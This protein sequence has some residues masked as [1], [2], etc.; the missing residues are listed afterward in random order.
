MSKVDELAGAM[1]T[2][3]KEKQI[4][5]SYSRRLNTGDFQGEEFFESRTLD[6]SE[7]YDV[8]SFDNSSTPEEKAIA[9]KKVIRNKLGNTVRSI[10]GDVLYCIL[11]RAT[12]LNL[13]YCRVLKA[14]AEKFVAGRYDPFGVVNECLDS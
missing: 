14:E 13:P 10:Y 4:V 9:L 2:V 12:E 1:S 7:A 5:I 8:L 3:V 6:F 11:N